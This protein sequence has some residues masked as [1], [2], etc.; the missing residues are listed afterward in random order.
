MSHAKEKTPE[1]F[2]MIKDCC[3]GVDHRMK[4]SSWTKYRDS[5]KDRLPTVPVGTG[6][7]CWR[8]PRIYIACHGIKASEL[9]E[10]AT[11]YDWEKVQP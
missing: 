8:V 7:A 4:R 5:V 9:P 2:I 10:L 6:L 1:I 3:C 11:L